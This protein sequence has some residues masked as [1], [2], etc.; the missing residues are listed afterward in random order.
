[1]VEHVVNRR[2]LRVCLLLSLVLQ[3]LETEKMTSNTLVGGVG[4]A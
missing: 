3:W 1:M 2:I 4:G